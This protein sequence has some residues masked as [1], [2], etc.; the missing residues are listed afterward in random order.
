M[1]FAA[2][3]FLGDDMRD[4][5]NKQES[6]SNLSHANADVDKH[7]GESKVSANTQTSS[8]T[9]TCLITV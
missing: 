2:L 6:T 4:N 9:S 1:S 8:S 5:N 3:T 7:V